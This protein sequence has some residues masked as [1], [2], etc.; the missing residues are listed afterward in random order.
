MESVKRLT[1]AYAQAPWRKQ[2]QMIVF[3]LLI[4]VM[5]ALIAGIYLNISARAVAAGVEIQD[6]EDEIENAEREIQ[7]LETKLAYLTS[8]SVMEERARD[9]GLEP[10]DPAQI[11]YLQVAGYPGRQG[12]ALAPPPRPAVVS[13]SPLSAEFTESLVDWV[14][15]NIIAPS[16]FLEVGQ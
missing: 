10:V 11:E 13:S 5:A 9:L 16:G 8:N 2:V 7:D 14:W 1:Q 6:L 15:K 12:P 3:F 4:L